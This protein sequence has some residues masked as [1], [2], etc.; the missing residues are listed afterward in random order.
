MRTWTVLARKT[1]MAE[2]P[3]F[4]LVSAFSVFSLPRVPFQGQAL[5]DAFARMEDKLTRLGQAFD[6]TNFKSQF[7]K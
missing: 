5:Q 3:S 7:K 4:D 1:L 6:K 2:F